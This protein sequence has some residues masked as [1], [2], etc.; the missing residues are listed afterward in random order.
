MRLLALLVSLLFLWAAGAA[1]AATERRIALIIGMGTYQY[2]PHLINPVNDAQAMARTLTDLGFDVEHRTDIDFRDLSGALRQFGIK[3][4]NADVALI[5]YAGHGMQVN[6]RNYLIPVDA[7]L[8]RERDLVYEAMPL[9]LLLG[10]VSQARTLGMVILDACRNNPFAERLMDRSGQI[11]RAA[12]IGL[13][14]ARVDDTPKDTLVAMATRADALAEDGEGDNSPYTDALLEYLEVPGLELGL[15]LRKV[16]DA[17][18]RTTNGRQEPYTFGSLGAEA[19]YFNPLP[20]NEPPVVGALEPLEI[21][22]RQGETA[23]EITGVEDPDGDPLKARITGL[24]RGGK[25]QF[26]SR[27][28]LIGDTLTAEQLRHVT[29]TPDGTMTG[30]AGPLMFAVEDTRGGIAFGSLFIKIVPSNHPPVVGPE[31]LVRV[32]AA[33]LGLEV[34][35][36]ED[37][38]D[39]RITVSAVPDRGVVRNAAG[40]AVRVGDLLAPNALQRLSFDPGGA[41]PGDAGAFA[42]VVEDEE[43]AK[44]EGTVRLSILS[45]DVLDQP[46]EAQVPPAMAAAESGDMAEEAELAALADPVRA[47]DAA[48]EAAPSVEAEPTAAA[49]ADDVPGDP[50]AD[51]AEAAAVAAASVAMRVPEAPEPA[52]DEETVMMVQTMAN[53]RAAPSLDGR[54]LAIAD[55]GDLVSVV[56]GEGGWASVRTD[57]GLEAFIWAGLLSP[58]PERPDVN[59]EAGADEVQ[60]AGA[61]PLRKPPAGSETRGAGTIPAVGVPGPAAEGAAPRIIKDCEDC[62]QLVV[63]QP[64]TFTMGSNREHPTARPAH[65]VTISEPFAIGRFEVTIGE[66]QACVDD[67]AC[68]PVPEASGLPPTL[69]IH[70]LDWH[71]AGAYVDWLADTTG[72]PYRLPTEAEWEY[73][74][75]GGSDDAFWWGARAGGG[76]ANCRGCGGPYDRRRPAAVDIF[77]ANGAGLYGTA[78]GV[79]EWVADCWTESHQG[80]PGDGSARVD[81][82]CRDRVLRGGSWRNDDSYATSASRFFYDAG[83]RYIANGLRVARDMR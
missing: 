59:S 62:P 36:D 82:A 43:G 44:A 61:L 65:R 54:R 34:P 71:D 41:Q 7:R 72:E 69:P 25:I 29:F 55:R 16:R 42:Y 24:P 56:G 9:D 49:A 32:I 22:D 52:G 76:E 18:L 1:Q 3:A 75:R 40:D 28:L 30:H 13:G 48:P 15:F 21:G 63:M 39:L 66:W 37:G 67:G 80:A 14:L 17:V 53:L 77:P 5:Y 60:I 19:F 8:E 4:Q 70:N 46:A 57:Q 50:E 79:A 45:P 83:V 35:T 74:A 2:A 23:L 78:G 11:S 38:D 20:P 12:Q 33:P 27:P 81:G 51:A 6:G 58:P 47:T 26:E 68:E 64:G 31:R 73:A 10:E